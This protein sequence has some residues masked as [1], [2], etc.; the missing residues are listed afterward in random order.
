MSLELWRGC[1]PR[2]PCGLALPTRPVPR[3]HWTPR[4]WFPGWQRLVATLL[5]REVTLSGR[6]PWERTTE[7]PG[8]PW[9]CLC[10]FPVSGCQLY[11]FA[12]I[13][14]TVFVFSLVSLASKGL[15]LS[16]VL[17]LLDST[18]LARCSACSL[19]ASLRTW[20]WVSASPCTRP[21]DPCL[22]VCVVQGGRT[23]PPGFAPAM[24]ATVPSPGG[25]RPGA[26][27]SFS[28]PKQRAQSV[29]RGS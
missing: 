19:I 14:D 27:L 20:A 11:P 5:L 28:S 6:L 26:P 16:V 13:N 8:I 7:R 1:R 22:Q 3:K 4:R 9:T 15:N 17:G 2:S 24:P 23:P 29:A 10:A 21:L 25:P 12:V 18:S